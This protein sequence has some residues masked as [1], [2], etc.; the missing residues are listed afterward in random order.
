MPEWPHPVARSK[1]GL[2]VTLPDDAV[3]LGVAHA[4]LGI[5]YGQLLL[6]GPDDGGDAIPHEMDGETFWLR[7]EVIAG[8]DAQVKVLSDAGMVVTLIPILYPGGRDRSG[9]GHEA[10]FPSEAALA[11]GRVEEGAEGWD[12]DFHAGMVLGFN[13]EPEGLRLFRAITEFLAE[14]YGRD[15]QRYGR[16]VNWVIGNEVDAH[17]FWYSIGPATLETLADQY[18]RVLRTAHHA[19]SAK[20][21]NGRIYTSLTHFWTTAA[22]DDPKLA[23]APRDLLD[24][25]NRLTKERGDFPWHVAYH[26]YPE[27]LFDPRFWEDELAVESPDSPKVTFKNLHVLT[28][29]LAQP[30]LRFDGEPRRVILSEQGFHCIDE[31]P[32]AEALQAAAYAYAYY[33]ADSLDGIDA[34]ILHRHVDHRGEGGLKLGLWTADQTVADLN[35]PDRRR[36]VYEVFRL[37]DTDRSLEV[38]EFAKPIIGITDWS[39]AIPGFRPKVA[40]HEG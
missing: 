22:H 30:H 31:T 40:R 37:I 21:P 18:E 8:L 39:D 36:A 34:F 26:P 28:D 7:G 3:A 13:A 35:T 6:A 2:Q 24:E 15:D 5:D 10:L 38:T 16:I 17:C 12:A 32:E 33:I 23:C 25:I 20:Q 19:V 4:A 1:K 27:D 9:A 11:R 29:H 14:R